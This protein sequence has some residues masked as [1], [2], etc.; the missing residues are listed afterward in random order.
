MEKEK[1]MCIALV[2]GKGK[3]GGGLDM[4][5]DE[6]FKVAYKIREVMAGV[7]LIWATPS[8][9]NGEIRVIF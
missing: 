4:T 5:L 9:F 7:G 1:P 8:P 6:A 2:G 3:L